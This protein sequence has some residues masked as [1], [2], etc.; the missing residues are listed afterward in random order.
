MW[1][2]SFETM[3]RVWDYIVNQIQKLTKYQYNSILVFS[4]VRLVV[5]DKSF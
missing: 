2:E 5:H 3:T 1:V 4:C